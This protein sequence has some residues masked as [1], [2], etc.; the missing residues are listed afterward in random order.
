[1]PSSTMKTAAEWATRVDISVDIFEET[2]FAE[3]R[4]EA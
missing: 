4:Q 3:P 2:I 1:M